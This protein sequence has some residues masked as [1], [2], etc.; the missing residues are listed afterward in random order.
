MIIL[1]KK[2]KDV[3][4]TA[5]IAEAEVEAEEVIRKITKK[6]IKEEKNLNKN[7][8]ILIQKKQLESKKLCLKEK[9]INKVNYFFN[10]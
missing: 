4:I 10:Y 7:R 5:D 1:L 6:R 3:D 9:S 8:L 2:I